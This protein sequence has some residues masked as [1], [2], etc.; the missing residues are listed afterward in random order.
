MRNRQWYWL[1]GL[2][3]VFG[4][5]WG[6]MPLHAADGGERT[7]TI[8]KRYLHLPV[9]NGA[10]MQ[11]MVYQIDG[12]TIREFDI[13]LAD[14]NPDFWVFSEL[15]AF[16]NQDITIRVNQ[17]AKGLAL[18]TA[19]DQVPAAENLYQEATRPQF[20]FSSRR[21][22]NNDPNGLLYYKGE[23]HLYYQHNPYGW[24][25]GNMHWGHAVSQD[26]V[27]WTE[28]PIAL[29]PQMHGDWCFSG[30]AVI[31][32]ANTS[33]FKTGDEEVL[34][35]AYTSTGR[36]ECIA[37]SNDRGRTFTEYEGNP[38]VTHQGRDPKLIWYAPDKIWVMAV[39]D[40]IEKSQG[41]A[42]YTSPDLKQWTR[43]SR[44]DG[45]YE[46]PEIFELPVD[47]DPSNTKWVLY[48]ADGA[49]ALGSFNGKTFTAESGKHPFALGPCFYASQTFS[50]IPPADG[51][52]IQIAWGR[53]GDRSMPFNQMMN[54]PVELTLRTTP[55]GVRLFAWPVEE[56]E[57]LY[58][59]TITSSDPLFLT[60]ERPFIPETQGDLLDLQLRILTPSHGSFGLSLF[61]HTLVYDA[62][63]QTL[64]C[65]HEVKIPPLDGVI[66]LRLLVDR[67]S[68]E[69]FANQGQVYIPLSV[70][71]TPEKR[72]ADKPV[73]LFSH[74]PA[75]T[76]QEFTL[77]TLR[78]SWQPQ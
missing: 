55:A 74:G 5:G 45:Y 34:V 2:I 1:L 33:G 14:A 77:H 12:Q 66:D 42:F 4:I 63:K 18:I 57:S 40:E 36:G 43:Q 56:I 13:E 35:V 47:G 28:L 20:H 71:F 78:S 73:I 30:S 64:A 24:N 22:W 7:L 26:L 38:V 27:H 72:A 59:Q 49:Y 48:A 9:K 31:D 32:T 8:E 39:Y 67:Q 29:Y 54:F 10:P 53:T 17:N 37:Y 50:D 44:V 41:I 15:T 65:P 23:Y 70:V 61:G 6:C 3:L 62:A 58:Q 60:P 51:R 76:L 69:I 11:R 68:I 19:S 52:R 21:G 46:C 75:V 25:W 16:A